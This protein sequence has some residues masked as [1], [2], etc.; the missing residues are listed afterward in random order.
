M[1]Q[2]IKT[3]ERLNVET[4]FFYQTDPLS[5]EF[6]EYFRSNYLNTGKYIDIVR[7]L[8]NNDLTVTEITTWGTREDFLEFLTDG[9]CYESVIMPQQT[10]NYEHGISSTSTTEPPTF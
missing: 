10:Y 4:L 9:I 1:F 7:T 8:S 6:K 2:L 3:S 5:E